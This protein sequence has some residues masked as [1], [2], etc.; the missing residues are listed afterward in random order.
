MDA[1]GLITSSPVYQ[2]EKDSKEI[3]YKT[4]EEKG[5]LTKD[6]FMMLFVT[7]LQY[8]DPMNPMES[9]EMASQMA[10]FNMLDLMY[11]NNEAMEQLAQTYQT[12]MGL[13][14]VSLLGHWVYHQGSSV[15]LQEAGQP[16]TLYLDL[17]TDAASAGLEI[18]DQEGAL[19]NILDLG[20][21]HEGRNTI[22][23]DGTDL[24][25]Q[26]VPPGSYRIMAAAQ[27]QNGDEMAARLWTQGRIV[28]IEY[29]EDNTPRL[30]LENGSIVGWDDIWTIS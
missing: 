20:P 30:Q 25:G 14:A 3:E 19:V 9:A 23:W 18:R 2:P 27:D 1:T 10:Q 11:K 21:L 4:A 16:Q 8:Q 15:T 12:S 28:K 7:Q 17:D 13:S 24:N 29:A 26:P 5:S 22:V 6:D